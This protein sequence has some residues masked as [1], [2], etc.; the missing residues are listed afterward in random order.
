MTADG[1]K[2][3]KHLDTVSAIRLRRRADDQ[4]NLKVQSVKSFQ[5]QRFKLT[6]ADLITQARYARAVQFFLQ[7]LYGPSDF[8]ARDQQFAKVVPALVRVFPAEIVH[9]VA[10]LSE[11]HALSERLDDEMAYAILAL[12]LDSRT[13][14][15]AW[16]QVGQPQSREEQIV[17]TLKIGIALDKLTR[18]IFLRQTLR[19]M[20]VPAHR[21]G[22]GALQSF[23]ETGFN[24]F[25]EMAGAD[26]FLQTI[27]SR[28]RALA[29]RFFSDGEIT[30]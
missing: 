10:T 18:N 3:L 4:F 24:I 25:R 9:T 26:F 19:I 21:A 13:Y 23:L 17:N 27:A 8:T 2:I 7:E 12:P 30:E 22:L 16:R 15:S 1:D 28:E 29:A 11:L 14:E 6:Y 20:R 5:H